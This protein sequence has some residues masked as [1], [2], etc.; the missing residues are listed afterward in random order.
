[1]VT[2]KDL[3][4]II[5]NMSEEEKKYFKGRSKKLYPRGTKYIELFNIIDKMDF[6]QKK[7]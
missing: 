1:M 4:R 6:F 3:F 5:K 7:F 2:T